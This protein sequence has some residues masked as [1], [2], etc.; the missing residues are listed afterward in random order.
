MILSS[1]D[2]F[3]GPGSGKKVGGQRREGATSPESRRCRYPRVG[4]ARLWRRQTENGSAG[5][6][7][8]E[9][10]G[11]IC[12]PS[13]S[14]TAVQCP[15]VRW[16]NRFVPSFL[17]QA[18]IGIQ[19]EKW[20]RISPASS[21]SSLP[22][23]LTTSTSRRISLVYPSSL[24]RDFQPA[25]S[26]DTS[27]SHRRIVTPISPFSLRYTLLNAL[28]CSDRPFRT[29]PGKF[30]TSLFRLIHGCAVFGRGI[31]WLSFD[32]GTF[33]PIR[34]RVAW[35]ATTWIR[36]ESNVTLFLSSVLDRSMNAITLNDCSREN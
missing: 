20:K 17:S 23:S 27:P 6:E 34:G 18:G 19:N 14:L 33:D 10:G 22:P 13:R 24:P 5:G 7:T 8:V 35:V 2:P 30:S 16:P 36:S 31:L 12:M 1:M 4:I 29:T 3:V 9:G 26:L 28:P 11:H 25:Y 15:P 32:G 21:S